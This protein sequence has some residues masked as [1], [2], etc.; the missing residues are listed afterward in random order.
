MRRLG[1]LILPAAMIGLFAA[2]AKSADG[3]N[4]VYPQ[5]GYYCSDIDVINREADAISQV[6]NKINS[7]ERRSLLAEQWIQFARQRVARSEA[8]REEWLTLQKQQTANQQEAQ[9]LRVEMLK[10]E[11]EIEKMRAENLKLQNEN[12]QL[13]LQLKQQTSG[14]TTTQAPP[15]QA[16]PVKT[17]PAK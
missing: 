5:P 12:L 8:F 4:Y 1:A 17:P 10:M 2:T 13:Q 6:L 9:Q 7:P 16:P 14:Q 15:T 11:G 3:Y